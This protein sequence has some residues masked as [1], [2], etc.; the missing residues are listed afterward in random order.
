[1]WDVSVVDHCS[2]SYVE[3]AAL[4]DLSAA[5]ARD[6]R[7]RGK[8]D[9][10]LDPAGCSSRG[11][12]FCPLSI[13]TSGAFGPAFASWYADWVAI[14]RDRELAAGG[15]GWQ[16]TRLTYHWQQRVV[17]ALFRSLAQRLTSRMT[18]H[19][20]SDPVSFGEFLDFGSVSVVSGAN[21]G[22]LGGW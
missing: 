10:P 17:V 18:V 6:S 19:A 16:T 13:E 1:M 21:G 11:H 12:T 15:S 9:D 14:E 3:G 5:R 7:K 22:D 4:H 8:Y 2:A 20:D